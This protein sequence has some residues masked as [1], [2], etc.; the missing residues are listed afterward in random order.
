MKRNETIK[1]RIEQIK[2][3]RGPST[4]NKHDEKKN[5]VAIKVKIIIDLFVLLKEIFLYIYIHSY[6]TL[7]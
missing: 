2:P 1:K 4:K 7:N 3:H 5:I 6:R